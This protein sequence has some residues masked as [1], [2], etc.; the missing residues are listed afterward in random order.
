MI[1]LS[2]SPHPTR[3]PLYSQLLFLL[4][5]LLPLSTLHDFLWL[6]SF[7]SMVYSPLFPQHFRV[8]LTRMPDAETFSHFKEE[9]RSRSMMSHTIF[10]AGESLLHK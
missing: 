6:F 4:L 10:N 3:G 1:V 7:L 2:S 9:V 8:S 5:L